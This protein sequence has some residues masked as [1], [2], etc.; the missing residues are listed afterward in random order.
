MMSN[1]SIT[2]D[3]YTVTVYIEG[4]LHFNKYVNQRCIDGLMMMGWN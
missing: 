4:G 2:K 3:M 1:G